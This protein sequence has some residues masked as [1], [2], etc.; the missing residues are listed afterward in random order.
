[1][2]PLSLDGLAADPYP[3]YAELRRGAP[4][5]WVPELGMWLVTRYNEVRRVLL[6]SRQFVTGTEHSLLFDTFGE[7]ML[8]AEGVTHRRYRDTRM[9][10]AF[11]P[12]AV[13]NGFG[14]GIERRVCQLVDEFMPSGRA[15]LRQ[16]FAARLPVLA[17]LDIFGLP[18]GDERLF[19]FWYDSFEC[20]L[21]NHR[22]DVQ[23]RR[24]AAEAVA[25]FHGYFQTHIHAAR[26][27]PGA[28]LLHTLLESTLTDQ[29]IRRN[30]LIIFFGGISTVE[31]LILNS[32]FALLTHPEAMAR[33][34][35][36]HS[37]IGAALEE[38]MRWQAPVQS[39]TR[40]TLADAMI[41]NICIPAGQTVN[42][43]LG[44]ANRDPTIFDNPDS[45]HLDRPNVKRHL[46]FAT[47]PHHCLGQ[48]LAKLQASK[49]LR[50]LFERT[51]SIELTEA[52]AFYGHEFRQ[53][54]SLNLRWRS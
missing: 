20:A 7:Q 5:I 1:M 48:H 32:L 10:L 47:G 18:D 12:Q 41:G 42:C 16:V 45:F 43:M 52:T 35:A 2:I 44:S 38:T 25:A 53:P 28:T 33:V 46:G 30:A 19:R 54:L 4:A 14:P 29:E 21:A 39:A 40:H 9:Q 34:R 6:D 24:Q 11:M 13:L 51:S 8:A 37:L 26:K 49:A 17:M 27:K 15:E 36:D 50:T 22:Q 31:A 3:F 23:V